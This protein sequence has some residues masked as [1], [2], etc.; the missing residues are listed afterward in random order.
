[1]PGYLQ[2]IGQNVLTVGPIVVDFGP[3]GTTT[4]YTLTCPTAAPLVAYY[5]YI[6]RFGASG[7]L[8]G[9][10][11]GSDGVTSGMEKKLEVCL[12]GLLATMGFINELLFDQW[13][14]LTNEDSDS[15]FDN[16]LIVGVH[17]WMN[18]NDKDVLSTMQLTNSSL[19]DAP[20]KADTYVPSYVATYGNHIA[21]TDTR[22]LQLA[23]EIVKQQAEYQR[24]SYVLRHTSYC[25]AGSLYNTAT[26]GTQMLYTNGQLL[27]EIGSGWN[28]NCPNRIISEIASIPQQFAAADEAAFYEWSWLKTISR[29]SN[30]TNFLVETSTE[31]ALGLWSTLRYQPY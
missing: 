12:P 2:N 21:P 19:S 27:S 30:L 31:Y 15:I 13:E 18:Q 20:G 7:V 9:C 8:Y 17:G 16:P 5:N 14:I 6:I 28:F 10:D 3:K 4:R 29:Q 23:K 22:S 11:Y 1:M 25:S 24:P 26:S